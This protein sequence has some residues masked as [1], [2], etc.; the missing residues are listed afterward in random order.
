MLKKLI[1]IVFVAL[2]I[3]GCSTGNDNNFILYVS[4]QSF[5]ISPVDMKIYVDGQLIID[6]DFEVGNQHNWK[7][8]EYKLGIGKHTIKAVSQ[9]G[10]AVLEEDFFVLNKRW[11]V[12]DYWS[13]QTTSRK[14]IFEI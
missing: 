5:D 6:D 9:K 10:D 4:D 1:L 12:L 2:L 11:A 8:Y 14:F 3:S 13:S 7:K